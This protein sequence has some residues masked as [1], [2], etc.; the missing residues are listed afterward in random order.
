MFKDLITG[1]KANETDSTFSLLSGNDNVDDDHYLV[2]GS[3]VGDHAGA[4]HRAIPS[5]TRTFAELKSL[6]YLSSAEAPSVTSFPVDLLLPVFP[7]LPLRIPGSSPVTQ[8]AIVTQID[9]AEE[10]SRYQMAEERRRRV[11]RASSAISQRKSRLRRID[12]EQ[13]AADLQ[14]RNQH[15]AREASKLE[16][17]IEALRKFYLEAIASG[18]WKCDSKQ[19]D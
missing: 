11:N 8:I 18:S 4:E 1:I 12:L 7:E 6:D 15:L 10:A 19:L 3:P 14:F 16:K 9:F 17:K 5:D 2:N 13:V